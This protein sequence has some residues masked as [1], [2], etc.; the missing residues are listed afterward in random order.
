M[1]V[2]NSNKYNL[3]LQNNGTGEWLYLHKTFYTMKRITIGRILTILMWGLIGALLFLIVKIFIVEDYTRWGVLANMLS[4]ILL[5]IVPL[6]ILCRTR[7]DD[8][9]KEEYRTKKEDLEKLKKLI[10]HNYCMLDFESI[11]YAFVVMSVDKI[12]VLDI[13]L[14][15]LRQ[16]ETQSHQSDLNMPYSNDEKCVN[17]YLL[18][19]ESCLTEYGRFIDDMILACG[20]EQ[21]INAGECTKSYI[22]GIDVTLTKLIET[23]PLAAKYIFAEG[24]LLSRLKE[25]Q[26]G[27]N[28]IDAV[29][30]SI[31]GRRNDLRSLYK[32]KDELIKAATVLTL[33]K[34]K[35]VDQYNRW[36]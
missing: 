17:D 6:Y 30:S 33:T 7:Q 3:R 12:Q 1:A 32:L 22:D 31:E 24:G 27:E 21:S 34:K 11:S 16:V 9:A 29:Q 4:T 26:D 25:I 13:L 14:A 36:D 8:K 15:L 5:A 35:E 20:I 19:F 23:S 18:T 2:R 28:Y 10:A